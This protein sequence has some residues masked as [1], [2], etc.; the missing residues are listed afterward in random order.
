VVS[1]TV[2]GGLESEWLVVLRAGSAG[3]GGVGSDVVDAG[4]CAHCVVC[5]GEEGSRTSAIVAQSEVV[6]SVIYGGESI[7]FACAMSVP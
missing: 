5:G 6:V 1:E 7:L 4:G 3:A 2:M